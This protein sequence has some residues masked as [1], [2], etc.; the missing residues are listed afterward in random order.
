MRCRRL[1]ADLDAQLK[2]ARDQLKSSKLEMHKSAIES[3]LVSE[4]EAKVKAAEGTNERM[5]AE[6]DAKTKRHAEECLEHKNVVCRVNTTIEKLKSE[7]A[8]LAWE[9]AA[10]EELQGS[11]LREM[12]SQLHESETATAAGAAASELD[13][14]GDQFE[15]I[16]DAADRQDCSSSSFQNA[17]E[18]ERLIQPVLARW[19]AKW[20]VDDIGMQARAT[21]LCMPLTAAVGESSW[22]QHALRAT[23]RQSEVRQLQCQ[24]IQTVKASHRLRNS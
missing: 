1:R 10:Q 14:F 19:E 17:H 5:E 2:A 6:M 18:N 8:S 22:V 4:L 20:T 24:H 11:M 13:D 3:A 12:E 16:S 9:H 7:L 15:P 21:Q 23:G